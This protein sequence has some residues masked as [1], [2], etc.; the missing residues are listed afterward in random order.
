M[1]HLGSSPMKLDTCF[2][3]NDLASLDFKNRLLIVTQPC[4]STTDLNIL[5]LTLL[6]LTQYT[7]KTLDS[8]YH[9]IRSWNRHSHGTYISFHSASQDY[10]QLSL[11]IFSAAFIFLVYH[12]AN[13]PSVLVS[14]E[15]PK[16]TMNLRCV[17]LSLLGCNF[18]SLCLFLHPYLLSY[19]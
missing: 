7:F 18:F 17:N 5:K 13:T 2:A 4:V 6:T 3:K 14:L 1:H 9:S 10:F 15:M 16:P 19:T 11:T 8:P 12:F